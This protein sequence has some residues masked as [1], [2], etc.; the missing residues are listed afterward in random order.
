[1]GIAKLM[2]AESG[3]FP[4]LA[5]FYHEEVTARGD[6]TVVRVLERGMARGEFRRI[7]AE[8]MKKVIV[9]PVVML[10]LWDQSLPPAQWRPSIHAATW[11]A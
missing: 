3:N 5:R 11:R 7:D 2:M 1:M 9:A 4:E 6:A 8:A 10:M